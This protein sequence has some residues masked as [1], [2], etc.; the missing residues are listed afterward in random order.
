M[1]KSKLSFFIVMF[2]I[3]A[4]AIFI[5]SSVYTVCF[6]GLDAVLSVKYIWGV[7]GISFVLTLAYLPFLSELSRTAYIIWN[8]V[9]FLFADFIVLL[10]GFFL[11]WFSLK[12]PVTIIGMEITFVVVFVT[13]WVTTYISI[14]H[15]AQKLN[16]QLKKIQK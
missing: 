15:S 12:H 11:G 13:V 2:S 3:L 5:F 10:T 4:T 7:L 16:E 14:K 1:N 6:A 8:I 9:Y